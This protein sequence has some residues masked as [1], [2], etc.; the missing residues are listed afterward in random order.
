MM[1]TDLDRF[2]TSRDIEGLVGAISAKFAMCTC[3]TT[4]TCSRCS[5]VREAPHPE[6]NPLADV[7]LRLKAARCD[8]IG[9]CGDDRYGDVE[10]EVVGVDVCD[11]DL[12]ID[13]LG[14]ALAD[15]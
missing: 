10:R 11:T 4:S 1:D 15:A 8:L 3:T 6:P 13:L 5:P 9:I 12:L 14:R 7:L 2:I